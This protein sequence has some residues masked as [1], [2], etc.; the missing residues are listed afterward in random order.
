MSKRT[1]RQRRL[2]KAARAAEQ[3]AGQGELMPEAAQASAVQSPAV[4]SPTLQ[5][6]VVESPVVVRPVEAPVPETPRAQ[7]PTVEA[8]V[9]YTPKFEDVS[10]VL[11]QLAPS[12]LALDL[13]DDERVSPV[14]FELVMAEEQPKTKK[15]EKRTSRVRVDEE[16]GQDLEASAERL[17]RARE[18]VRDG[19]IEEAMEL[20]REIVSDHPQSL[21]ARNNL[22][23]LYDELGQ[24][25]RAL[26]QF[27][28]A[29]GLAP[30]NVEVLSNMGAALLGL[31]RFEDAE[32][33]LRRAQ[34]IDA[35]NVEVHA[36]LGILFHRRG[37][38]AQ[39]ET[40][41]RWVC[42]HDQDHGPAHFYRGEALNRL[43]RVDQ[44]LDV[45]ERALRLQPANS[46]IY[47]TMGI[48]YDKKHM[49]S[50]AAQMYRKMREL[51]S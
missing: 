49:P 29:H 18:K 11:E 4:Q 30:D 28:I 7:P 21:K 2:S 14:K 42:E 40:E 20:Y 38:Y 13:D 43:G 35:E 27:E 12:N 41:L 39:A 47:H 19:R 15:S 33:E 23:V 31:S 51:R 26:E 50:E 16:P 34:K 22:G 44:A 36:N 8:P 48:L 17:A 9:V 1:R 45:L 5:S 37:L 10:A 6:P 32:R 24:H 3:K 46:K 25:E